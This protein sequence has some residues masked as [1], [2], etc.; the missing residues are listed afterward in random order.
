MDSEYSNAALQLQQRMHSAVSVDG[1]R[2]LTVKA[3]DAHIHILDHRLESVQT[4]TSAQQSQEKT[5]SSSSASTDDL[6]LTCV[7]ALHAHID[8]EDRFLVAAA[9]TSSNSIQ[10]W[11]EPRSSSLFQTKGRPWRQ[12]SVLTL[13]SDG[14]DSQAEQITTFDLAV[15]KLPTPRDEPLRLYNLR[16]RDGQPRTQILALVGSTS[17]LSLWSLSEVGASSWK[18]EWTRRTPSR[19]VCASLTQDATFAAAFVE[20]DS[21]AM[22]WSITAPHTAGSSG[23]RTPSRAS[24]AASVAESLPSPELAQGTGEDKLKERP[25]VKLIDRLQHSRPLVSIEWRKP[26]EGPSA[27]SDPLL[28]TQTTDGTARI[29]A[30]VIDQPLQFRLWSSVLATASVPTRSTPRSGVA[31]DRKGKMPERVFYL[32]AQEVTMAFRAHIWE[33]EKEH[34]R[35]ELGVEDF[36]LPEWTASTSFTSSDGADASKTTNSTDPDATSKKRKK[37]RERDMRRT[38]LQRL[39]QIVSETPDMFLTHLED[40]TLR[41]TAVANIDRSPPTLFQSM[42]ISHVLRLPRSPASFIVSARFVPMLTA[43]SIATLSPREDGA[44]RATGELILLTERGRELRYAVV[45]GLLFDGSPL[46][47]KLKSVGREERRRKQPKGEETD[48]D[49]ILPLYHPRMLNLAI[50]TGHLDLASSAVIQLDARIKATD[51]EDLVEA[52]SFSDEAQVF[53]TAPRLED[54]QNGLEE[55]ADD[56]AAKT[57]EEVRS[58]RAEHGTRRRIEGLEEGQ[59]AE[60]LQLIEVIQRAKEQQKGLDF[61]GARF[62]TALQQA[63]VLSEAKSTQSSKKKKQTLRL[64]LSG[65]EVAWAAHSPHQAKL[66]QKIE[67]LHGGRLSWSAA[68]GTSLFL[69]L[70]GPPESVRQHAESL[71]RAQYAGGPEDEDQHDPTRCSMLYYAL[72]KHKLVL[73]LWRQAGWHPDSK[74]MVQFLQNDFTEDRWRTAALKNAF[75]LMSKRKFELAGAFF[76]LGGSLKDAT[77]VCARSLE[78]VELAVA[79][80]RIAEGRDDG[81]VLRGVLQAKLLP[82]ALERG[83]RGLASLALGMLGEKKL[84]REVLVARS[85]KDFVGQNADLRSLLGD[86]LSTFEPHAGGNDLSA[87]LLYNHLQSQPDHP[88]GM[89]ECEAEA[90]QAVLDHARELRRQG[91]DLFALRLVLDWKFPSPVVKKAEPASA[92]PQADTSASKIQDDDLDLPRTVNAK[93]RAPP[94][95]IAASDELSSSLWDSFDGPAQAT[96]VATT[97]TP[98]PGPLPA[99]EP[100]S[101]PAPILKADEQKPLP[102][103]KT[104]LGSLIKPTSEKQPQQGGTEFD[105]SAFGF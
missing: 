77:N 103:K 74:K 95:A 29:W 66:V 49:T 62:V 32:G 28:I 91:C 34:M 16:N 72:G 21:R 40:G 27:R 8:D 68:S 99:P 36:H 86:A 59:V 79:V 85:L 61:C 58:D 75:A 48:N 84:E 73:N 5:A 35:A 44:S 105:M 4:L 93:V 50:L 11:Q 88:R 23:F 1:R 3:Q 52:P 26:A 96:P 92:V 76:L 39:Q 80:A 90:K 10:F 25:V 100:S 33:L 15:R 102:P 41:I 9:S 81:P 63:A 64:C 55:G 83:D 12:H 71:A 17:S 30:T 20:K 19:V 53:A 104:G 94:P 57:L 46:G 101:I 97:A 18:R 98:A 87:L 89:E 51:P 24:G 70:R 60:I 31:S 82:L 6:D 69:W 13:V 54:K 14:P 65:S 2:L 78:D 22:V 7:R 42:T 56:G 37:D 38:R 43:P 45:P 47:L 67:E